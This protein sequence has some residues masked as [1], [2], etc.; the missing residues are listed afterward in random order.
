MDDSFSTSMNDIPLFYFFD[1]NQIGPWPLLQ[2]NQDAEPVS[3]EQL[4]GK[5]SAYQI[6]SFIEMYV[7]PDEK[8][9]SQ[10]VIQVTKTN[11]YY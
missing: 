10:F 3:V 7:I 9:S 8:S 1:K 11:Y 5:L 6:H 4:I 2:E